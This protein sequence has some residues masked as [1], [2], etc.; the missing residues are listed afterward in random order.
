MIIIEIALV[1]G[2]SIVEIALVTGITIVMIPMSM[3]LGILGLQRRARS[4]SMFMGTVT[5]VMT[6]VSTLVISMGMQLLS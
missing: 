4:V 2:I 6:P 5:L 1:T 3:L